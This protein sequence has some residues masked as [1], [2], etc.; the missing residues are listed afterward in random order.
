MFVP[1]NAEKKSRHILSNYFLEILNKNL[2]IDPVDP[3]FVLLYFTLKSQFYSVFRRDKFLLKSFFTLISLEYKRYNTLRLL[4]FKHSYKYHADFKE[5][6][7]AIPEHYIRYL[8]RNLN[9]ILQFAMMNVYDFF[10]MLFSGL[11]D[12]FPEGQYR[13]RRKVQKSNKNIGFLVNNTEVVYD[14]MVND[15]KC[16]HSFNYFVY[17]LKIFA[18][19]KLYYSHE[20][21]K[22]KTLAT[23]PF[24]SNFLEFITVFEHNTL[25]YSKSN[26]VDYVNY[27]P[28]E[29]TVFDFDYNK[30]LKSKCSEFFN[31]AE[32]SN[33]KF[34]NTDFWFYLVNG[35]INLYSKFRE[36]LLRE[37]TEK[38]I[39]RRITKKHKK[40]Y[41][42]YIER[43]YLDMDTLYIGRFFFG[44]KKNKSYSF[45]INDVNENYINPNNLK[46]S[47][48][49]NYKYNFNYDFKKDD[50]D[51]DL[52][53]HP[54]KSR[55]LELFRVNLNLNTNI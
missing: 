52:S 13:S 11:G 34:L 47:Y 16:T 23:N 17:S 46:L 8:K 10:L 15:I 21:Y 37:V 27:K 48:N 30:M 49:E 18:L 42:K 38:I 33:L 22:V 9:F 20:S 50:Y 19:R 4:Q 6:P 39:K 35:R 51:R 55:V 53:M 29:L 31:R 45:N 12:M 43:L 25:Q 1:L 28:N 40:K 14:N 41:L 54:I 5:F 2:N 24:Y 36:Y 7:D 26:M 32:Y 44:L 3:D